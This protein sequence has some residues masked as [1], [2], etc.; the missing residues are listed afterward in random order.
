MGSCDENHT[1]VGPGLLQMENPALDG[2]VI[3]S[4]SAMTPVVLSRVLPFSRATQ[5]RK[6][7][8]QRIKYFPA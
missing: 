1:P 8:D 3:W 6:F 5:K 7:T 4:K 2:Q